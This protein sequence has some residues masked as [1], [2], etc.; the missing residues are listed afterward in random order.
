MSTLT[1]STGFVL[2]DD[3]N[4]SN[5]PSTQFGNWKKSQYNITVSKPSGPTKYNILPGATQNVFS[6]VRTLTFDGTTQFTLSLNPVKSATYRMSA[7]AGTAAG[8]RT[9]RAADLNGQNVTIT[10]NNNALANFAQSAA[11]TGVT[12]GDIFFIPSVLTG[13]SAGPFNEQ[14]SGYWQVYSISGTNFTAARLT[15]ESF[16][17]VAETVSVTSSSQIVFFSNSGVQV[18]DKLQIVSGFSSVSKKTYSISNISWNWVEFVS[19][20]PLPLESAII[21]GV[22]GI[23]VYNSAK[24]WIRIESDQELVLRFNGDTGNS[25]TIPPRLNGSPDS[26]SWFDSWGLFYSLDIVNKSSI[27]TANVIIAT[28]E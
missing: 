24:R 10:I 5:N 11:L 26:V 16:S 4:V 7:V 22:G 1:H 21:V 12:V 17:G 20:E 25:L 23:V 2:Y 27:S 6:G 15:G 28:V 3:S 14:N 13:D 19:T 18:G 8:F 9:K